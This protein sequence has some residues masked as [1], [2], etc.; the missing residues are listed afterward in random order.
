MGTYIVQHIP[1]VAYWSCKLAD[2]QAMHTKGEIELLTLVMFLNK[3]K[4]MP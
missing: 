1:Q 2:A 4:T 3:I